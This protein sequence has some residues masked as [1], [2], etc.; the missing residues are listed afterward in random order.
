MQIP[1]RLERLR[2]EGMGTHS[3]AGLLAVEETTLSSS[4]QACKLSRIS[5]ETVM[6][7]FAQG[8]NCLNQLLEE[9]D[10]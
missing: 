6:P 8:I 1:Q 10:D 5:H 7:Y 4:L 9:I 2:D 3:H